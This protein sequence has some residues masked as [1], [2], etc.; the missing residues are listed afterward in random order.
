MCRTP[1]VRRMTVKYGDKTAQITVMATRS[2][3]AERRSETQL[4]CTLLDKQKLVIYGLVNYKARGGS[5]TAQND[6]APVYTEASIQECPADTSNTQLPRVSKGPAA[7]GHSEQVF[8]PQA[9][10]RRR[11]AD[12]YSRYNTE[13]D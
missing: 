12:I 7:V 2:V 3:E 1:V 8:L 9:I 10:A 6:T 5:R 13:V 4:A 11:A